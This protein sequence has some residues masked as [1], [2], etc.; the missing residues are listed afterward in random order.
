M[1]CLSPFLAQ[2]T[3]NHTKNHAKEGNDVYVTVFGT[4]NP[5]LCKNYSKEG[6]EV[7][8]TI[9]L[10]DQSKIVPKIAPNKGMMCLS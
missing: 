10:H 2:Q 9:F 1:M 4:T 8:F 6:D 7:F 5:K 3:Q